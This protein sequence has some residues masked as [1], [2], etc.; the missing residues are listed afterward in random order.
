MLGKRFG[1][2]TPAAAAAVEGLESAALQAFERGE[3]VSI[4]VNGSS[5]ELQPDDVILTRSAAGELVVA[6]DGEYVAAVDPAL[7]DGLR[8]EGTARELVSRIQRLRKDSGFS[9]SDRIRLEIGGVGQVQDAA[10]EHHTWIAGEVL[11]STL[12]VSDSEAAPPVSVAVDLDGIAA[13]FTLERDET[14]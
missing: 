9:V 13:W 1:K 5:H 10:R 14:R 3:S 2:S 6:G 12:D 7:T 4:T 8:R 11:A